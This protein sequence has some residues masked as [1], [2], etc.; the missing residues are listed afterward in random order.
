MEVPHTGGY[1]GRCVLCRLILNKGDEMAINA[2]DEMSNDV[3]YDDVVH[4]PPSKR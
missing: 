3:W 2:L 4:T 1:L